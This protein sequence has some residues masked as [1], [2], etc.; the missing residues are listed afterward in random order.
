M[1][2]L[3]SY[4]YKQ[5]QRTNLFSPLCSQL[6]FTFILYHVIILTIKREDNSFTRVLAY[7]KYNKKIHPQEFLLAWTLNHFYKDIWSYFL[8]TLWF[9]NIYKKWYFI[10]FWFYYYSFYLL[11]LITKNYKIIYIHNYL[12]V[13]RYADNF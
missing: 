7:R 6:T 4:G 3:L 9:Q 2:I 11:N 1:F 5:K 10:I 13:R 8:Q 12:L